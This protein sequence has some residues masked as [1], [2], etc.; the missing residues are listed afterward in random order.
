[1]DDLPPFLR[2][3]FAATLAAL[4]LLLLVFGFYAWRLYPVGGGL[5]VLAGAILLAGA[6]IGGRK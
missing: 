6:A 2:R 3:L 4:G 1:M 5:L